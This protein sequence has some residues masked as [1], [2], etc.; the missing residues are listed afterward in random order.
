MR[1]QI[2]EQKICIHVEK[3]N[4]QYVLTFVIQTEAFS[5]IHLAGRYINVIKGTK[6]NLKFCINEPHPSVIHWAV[7]REN[8]VY[9]TDV[10]V[11]KSTEGP[12][13][14]SRDIF[15]YV[16][17][18]NFPKFFGTDME[19]NKKKNSY[20]NCSGSPIAQSMTGPTIS[21]NILFK[22]YS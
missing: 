9:F 18:A 10:A 11:V 15:N 20:D 17:Q 16:T 3:R 13:S 14:I 21:G 22:L 2:H 19:T 8:V 7:H 4:D 12:C 1:F 6:R 5:V